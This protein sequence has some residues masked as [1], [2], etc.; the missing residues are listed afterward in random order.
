MRAL[1][2]AGHQANTA[3]LDPASLWQQLADLSTTEAL[4][5][6][7]TSGWSAIQRDFQ[8]TLWEHEPAFSS[9]SATGFT[10]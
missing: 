2:R 10:P 7:L 5:F 6:Y 3:E 9:A 4:C 8:I 1:Y